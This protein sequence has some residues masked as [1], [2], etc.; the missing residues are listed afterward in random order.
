MLRD[1]LGEDPGSS[2]PVR[3]PTVDRWPTVAEVAVL[4]A[5]WLP[6]ATE[7]AIDTDEDG[8]PGALIGV[9][10]LSWSMLWYANDH[11]SV[12]AHTPERPLTEEEDAAW[13]EAA[14]RLYGDRDTN[15]A[16]VWRWR[17]EQPPARTPDDPCSTPSV[18]EEA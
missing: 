8:A 14:E 13:A 1:L 10:G 6:E 15:P 3:A 9:P 4:I 17:V 5:A 11:E 7:I 12:Y 16:A 2:G 18:A